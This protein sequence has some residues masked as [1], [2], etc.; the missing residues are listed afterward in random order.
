MAS[1]FGLI[2]RFLCIQLYHL[3]SETSESDN[4]FEES[5]CAIVLSAIYLVSYS[6]TLPDIMIKFILNPTTFKKNILRAHFF[7]ENLFSCFYEK[8]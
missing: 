5:K 4:M 3:T 6:Y 2:N 8:S 7:V 1:M